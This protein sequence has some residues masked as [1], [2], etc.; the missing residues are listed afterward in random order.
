MSTT[1]DSGKALFVRDGQGELVT[2]MPG[3]AMPVAAFAA[4]A[5]AQDAVHIAEEVREEERLANRSQEDVAYEAYLAGKCSKRGNVWIAN[6]G[7]ASTDSAY[8]ADSAA[9]R[10]AEGSGKEYA[11]AR[12]HDRGHKF[13]QQKTSGVQAAVEAAET[14]AAQAAAAMARARGEGSDDEDEAANMNALQLANRAME[15]YNRP[16]SNMPQLDPYGSDLRV[17]LLQ[18]KLR[19]FMECFAED[20]EVRSIEGAAVLRDFEALRKRYGTVFRES[21]SELKGAARKRWYYEAAKEEGADDED[22]AEG[23]TWCIDLERHTSLVTPKP[24]LSL[25]GSLGCTP[26]RSQDLVV[27]YH[28]RGSEICGMWIAP[29]KEDMGGKLGREAIE[30]TPLFASFSQQI[31][32]LSGGDDLTCHFNDYAEF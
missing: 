19:K 22:E 7:Q 8:F 11:P 28:A 9:D 14:G 27:L 32:H 17:P 16:V 5:E 24:G 21:G 4:C 13:K 3:E 23:E 6:A 20:I 29:D 30:A 31:E 2:V 15:L 26:P 25:D 1:N 12:A 10:E 18:R